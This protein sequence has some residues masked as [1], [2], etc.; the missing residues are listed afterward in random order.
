M[1]LIDDASRGRPITSSSP[2]CLRG[3]NLVRVRSPPSRWHEHVDRVS[4][5][6]IRGQWKV[7]YTP[8]LRV[9]HRPAR[10]ESKKGDAEWGAYAHQNSRG[11]R[12]SISES[13][14]R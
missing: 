6:V 9:H 8:G 1:R 7:G 10:Y 11:K 4:A 13:V 2:W 3:V 14:I 5:M 12:T